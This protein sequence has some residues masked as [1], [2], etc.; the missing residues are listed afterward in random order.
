MIELLG[1]SGACCKISKGVSA[2]IIRDQDD[3]EVF[4]WKDELDDLIKTLLKI[5][6][7]GLLE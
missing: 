1:D 3:D 6:E 5:K 4:I 2:V 7:E